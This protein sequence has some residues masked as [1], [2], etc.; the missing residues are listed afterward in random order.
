[1]IDKKA[2]CDGMSRRPGIEVE[3][4]AFNGTT[5]ERFVCHPFWF[6]NYQFQLFFRST[7]ACAEKRHSDRQAW[8]WRG[9]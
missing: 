4:E 1:M 2:R 6:V 7:P 5:I 9:Q 8:R 3:T